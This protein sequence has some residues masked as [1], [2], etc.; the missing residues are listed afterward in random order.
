MFNQ[1]F[2]VFSAINLVH[3]QD[4]TFE[5]YNLGLKHLRIVTNG[6]GYIKTT[7]DDFLTLKTSKI[8]FEMKL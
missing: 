8:M 5:R 1:M 6:H 7:E 2:S 4:I 3:I